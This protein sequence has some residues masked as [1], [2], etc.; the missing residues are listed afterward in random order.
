TPRPKFLL[1][2]Y[3]RGV[4]LDSNV[5]RE[6]L[7]P[8]RILVRSG[9]WLGDAIMSVPA[10]RAIKAGR[11]DAHLTIA[12]PE[13]IASVWKLVPEVDEIVPLKGKSL[14]AAAFAIR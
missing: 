4:Y 1:A 3:K 12:V 8:F 11:P 10:V 14:L 2:R 13:K 9:N 6:S 7:K 5:A